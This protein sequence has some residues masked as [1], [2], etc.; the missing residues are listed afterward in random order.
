[1]KRT[2]TLF[3]LFGLFLTSCINQDQNYVTLKGHILNAPSD[4][5]Y[6][7]DNFDAYQKV[8]I[9]DE[10]NNF[11]DTLNISS[12]EYYFEIGE[13]STNLFLF[14]GDDMEITLDY[15]SFDETIN[16]SGK[17]QKINNYL[18]KRVLLR[19]KNIYEDPSFFEKDSAQFYH[20]LN[21]F[22]DKEIHTLERLHLDS[23]IFAEEKEGI[24]MTKKNI[25]YFYRS[26][27]ELKQLALLENAPTF[28]LKDVNENDVSLS[29]FKGNIILIDV[30]ATWCKPCLN[31]IPDLKALLLDYEESNL[32]FVGISI[33]Q[34]EDIEL[35]KE[36]IV[37]EQLPGTQL[38]MENGWQSTF[39]SD[40]V[41]S[42]VPR[43]ILIDEEGKFIDVDA[44][45]PSEGNKLRILIDEH[46]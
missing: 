22:F 14:E 37:E 11:N 30:W 1:M 2:F 12:A 10:Y 23:H 42:S 33:D 31:E 21:T 25:G 19:E 27:Q 29:D 46:L 34:Q 39:K 24:T 5:I 38:I 17:G 45:R 28:T 32:R 3:T 35:W 36:K 44:P 43:F 7:Y 20:D 16:A 15:L 18:F 9:L 8:I 40:Y 41:V 4:T 26:K 13:E 6:I